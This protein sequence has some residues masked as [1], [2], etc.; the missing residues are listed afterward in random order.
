MPDDSRIGPEALAARLI[1]RWGTAEA[2]VR[3][4]YLLHTTPKVS[5]EY[6]FFTRLLEA[7]Q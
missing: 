3:A 5:R 4:E 6:E 7:I 1:A 2:R